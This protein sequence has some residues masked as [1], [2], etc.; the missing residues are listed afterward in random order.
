M[1]LLIKKSLKIVTQLNFEFY[2]KKFCNGNKWNI[3]NHRWGKKH[4]TIFYKGGFFLTK[5]KW[6]EANWYM[7]L[8]IISVFIVSLVLFY[9]MPP[10]VPTF[11][12]HGIDQYGYSPRIQTL[13]FAPPIILIVYIA[14]EVFGIANASDYFDDEDNYKFCHVLNA[15][16]T[17]ILTMAQFFTL[18]TAFKIPSSVGMYTNFIYTLIVIILGSLFQTIHD[19]P[20]TAD[21]IIVFP[22]L[23]KNQ[24]VWSKTY[25]LV[26]PI[27]VLGGLIN[28]P[29]SIFPLKV[30]IF[31]MI[32]NALILLTIYGGY[33]YFQA[34]LQEK[35]KGA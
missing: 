2:Y 18:L 31:E 10:Q 3:T 9:K 4:L 34:K 26:G 8:M 28:L 25:R 13:L 14:F 35:R 6:A 32:L 21:L 33:S 19:E 16:I 20:P 17:T 30:I 29:F 24:T 22:W 7:L 12:A 15:A 5:K 1:S 11:W 27:F 23:L